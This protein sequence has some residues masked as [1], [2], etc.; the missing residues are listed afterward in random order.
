MVTNYNLIDKHQ[1]LSEMSAKI[2]GANAAS[3]HVSENEAKAACA[4]ISLPAPGR[5]GDEVGINNR[6]EGSRV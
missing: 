2:G 5:N 1:N 6:G 4:K 3:P